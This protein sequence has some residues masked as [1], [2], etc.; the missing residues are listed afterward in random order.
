MNKAF[1]IKVASVSTIVGVILVLLMS[2]LT[3][4]EFATPVFPFLAILSAYLISGM[5]SGLVSKGE[6]IAEPGVSSI[7]TGIITF[8]VI[9]SMG[10]HCFDKLGGEVFN[11][12]MILLTLN[13]I[14][15]T[16]AGA[17]AG[18]KLQGTFEKKSK[19]TEEFI[20]WGWIMAGTIFGVTVS[21]FLSNIIIKL[22]GL[23]L[24]PLFISLALGLFVTGW[25][26]GLRSPGVTI[27]EAAIAGLLTAVV[28]LDIFKFTLDPDTTTL[29]SLTIFGTLALGMIAALIGAVAGEKMQEAKG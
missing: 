6:T 10:L 16:F 26:I 14:I 19:T 7:L 24:S 22:F 9:K 25:I 4:N 28:N 20:E 27:K 13:G 12:N 5:V 1:D 18:E 23:N 17:W 21:I 11:V 29:T 2:W 8:F 15:L 3:G